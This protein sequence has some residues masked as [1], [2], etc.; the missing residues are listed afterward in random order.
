MDLIHFRLYKMLFLIVLFTAA[1]ISLSEIACKAPNGTESN[2]VWIPCSGGPIIYH[3]ITLVDKNR[4]FSFFTCNFNNSIVSDPR[5][6]Q[7][8]LVIHFILIN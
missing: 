4:L 5:S 1:D 7:Y 2:F 3:S 6:T 8:C